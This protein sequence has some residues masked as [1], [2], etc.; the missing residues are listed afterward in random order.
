[1]SAFEEFVSINESAYKTISSLRDI[2]YQMQINALEIVKKFVQ[3]R[4]LIVY[5]GLAIDYALRLKGKYLYTDD[6]IPDYDIYSPRHAE[7]TYDLADILHKEGFLN[8]GAI[9]AKHSQ[10]MRVKT[11]FIFVADIT[12]TP[13]NIYDIIP[14][15]EYS[16]FRIVDPKFQIM[17]IHSSLSFPFYGPPMENIYYRWFRDIDRYNKLIYLYP[18]KSKSDCYS[19]AHKITI[20]A[21]IFDNNSVAL[22]SI[23]AFALLSKN[24][25]KLFPK[26]FPKFLEYSA[27]GSDTTNAG[28]ITYYSPIPHK[29]I[30]ITTD[31]GI[32]RTLETNEKIKLNGI[33]NQYV[34]LR[35]EVYSYQ[36]YDVHYVRDS[37]LSVT[38]TKGIITPAVHYLMLHF[39]FM[40]LTSDN[41]D[42]ADMYLS[43]YNELSRMIIHINGALNDDKIK[44]VLGDNAHKLPII[45]PLGLSLK[46]MGTRNYDSSFAINM[47]YNY[48]QIKDIPDNITISGKIL[49]EVVSHLPAQYMPGE[50]QRPEPFN[51]EGSLFMRNGNLR[52]NV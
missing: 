7:D 37:L 19:G 46:T 2:D 33:Y 10:T 23:G 52:S 29:P 41:A 25:N 9:R 27:D 31:I 50:K 1:M 15:I 32:F 13:K 26:E 51:Y 22:H 39:M 3:E 12:Y 47:G 11:D 38:K 21:D 6:K 45:N 28:V 20:A 49:N 18:I 40:N 43:F 48:R 14:T 5:G 34:D 30:V 36:E 42:N 17:D 44:E 16:G 4:G 24:M 8:V 35:P